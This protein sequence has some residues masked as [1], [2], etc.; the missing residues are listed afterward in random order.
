M[1]N[2]DDK[3]DLG[4]TDI[5]GRKITYLR[6]SLTKQCNLRCRYCY[7][8]GDCITD[9]ESRLSADE[10]TRLIK[11][12]AE[13]G[14][15]KIRFT[16][17]EPLLRKEIVEL[18]R[19]TAAIENMSLIGITTNGV[20]LNRLLN[21]LVDAGLNRINISLD[22]LKPERFKYITGSDGIE[23][24]LEAIDMA[25]KSNAFPL[26]KVNTIA[27]RGINDDE[28]S[29]FAEW[30]ISRKIDLRFIEFMPAHKSGWDQ[31]RFIDEKEM[32]KI[33]T[34]PLEMVPGK[35]QHQ[36]PAKSYFCPG[37]PG[38]ISFISAVS[39]SFCKECNRLRITSTGDLVGCLF[40]AGKIDLRNIIKNAT[41]ADD[42]IKF[43]KAKTI[44]PGFRRHPTE[45]SISEQQPKMRELGG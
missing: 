10:L 40:G 3:N 8:S 17:G 23:T 5:V 39:R 43:L 24:V 7:G 20:L 16:G 33:I 13:L 6:I 36:G 18:V 30:A 31:S 22:T 28:I 4:L 29:D 42:I 27:M 14:I 1:K 11:A 12:F 45:I 26:V 9:S 19:Q 38:R 21:P 2:P 41:G 32:R 37:K 44:T 15:G 34:L 35:E 25:V